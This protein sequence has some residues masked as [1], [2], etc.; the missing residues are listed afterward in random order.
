MLGFFWPQKPV[1]DDDLGTAPACRGIER[2]GER[3]TRFLKALGRFS[4]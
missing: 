4:F 2:T 3:F 1:N